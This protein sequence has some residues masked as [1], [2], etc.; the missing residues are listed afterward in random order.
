M[1]RLL[2][3]VL[4]TAALVLAACA[5]DAP[6]S[7]ELTGVLANPFTRVTP[8]VSP[9]PSSEPMMLF[10]FEGAG[11]TQWSIEND[12]VMGGRSQGFVEI[13]RGTLVFTGEVVTEGRGGSRRSAPYGR[14]TF[15]ATTGSS[16]ASAVVGAR[17]NWMSTTGRGARVVR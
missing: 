13:D 7:A 3:L 2:A 12:G 1:S 4:T 15:R 16:S 8:P 11:A 6:A 9:M 17:S 5:N 10:D 14:Q